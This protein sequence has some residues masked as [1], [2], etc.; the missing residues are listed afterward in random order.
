MELISGILIYLPSQPT[1]P[2]QVRTALDKWA[3][4][5]GQLDSAPQVNNIPAGKY[6]PNPANPAMAVLVWFGTDSVVDR[7]E[8]DSAWATIA[9][10]DLS[11]VQPGSW[12]RQFHVDDATGAP[13]T[14][15]ERLF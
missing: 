1:R 5:S 7:A 4:K 14:I 13:T 2:Q 15:N 10:M 12:I 9:G 3:A 11:W 6:G 8:A